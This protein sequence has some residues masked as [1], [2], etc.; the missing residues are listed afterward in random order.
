[1]KA[2]GPAAARGGGSDAASAR[3]SCWRRTQ[4]A[5]A[6]GA[7]RAP[8]T[9]HNL[10]PDKP[11]Y[12][13]YFDYMKRLVLHFDFGYSYQSSVAVKTLIFD[14]LPATVSLTIGAAVVW[15]VA[16]IAIGTISAVRRRSLFDRLA[17]GG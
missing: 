10:G 2:N 1:M 13:Q 17:M 7:A 9:R 3:R 8:Q 5:P 16:G 12:T 14:R 6:P 15:L 4:T 11:W